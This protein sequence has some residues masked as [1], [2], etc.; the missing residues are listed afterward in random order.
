MTTLIDRLLLQP[1]LRVFLLLIFF[2]CII[3]FWPPLTGAAGTSVELPGAARVV[4]AKAGSLINEKNYKEAAKLIVTF[5]RQE[6]S[7]RGCFAAEVYHVLGICYLLDNKP[8]LAITALDKAIASD[9]K[10]LPARLNRAKAGYETGQYRDAAEHF[11]AAY[12]LAENKEPEHL[13]FAAV[14]YL[15]AK[16]HRKSIALFE[17]LLQTNPDN[18]R[19]EWRE[20]LVHAL[21]EVKEEKLALPHIVILAET[22]QGDKQTQWW[23]ILLN[24]Y[25]QLDMHGEAL[26]LARKLTREYPAE[27]KWWRGLAHIHLF[28]N[29][30]Q[31]A[32]SAMIILGYL[33]PL[34]AQEQRLVADLY[35]QLGVPGQAVATYQRL[36]RE[37]SSPQLLQNVVV[38]FQQ[39]GEL[40]AAVTAIDTFG[41][42]TLSP[43]LLM[44]KGDLLYR[45]GKFAAAAE[46]YSQ[47]AA[48]DSKDKKRAVQMVQYAR[49]QAVSAGL[50]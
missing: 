29:Q 26:A 14:A 31:P 18:F 39:L 20:N 4:L 21:L 48:L 45:L 50:N 43:E 46:M 49:G 33:V 7:D 37:K 44:Q 30:Y 42:D 12:E 10:H 8:N 22:C 24:E 13:Y 5:Q 32:L 9:P 3:L 35:L 15:L 19:L 41:G 23:E 36:L 11:Y 17:R 40:E 27:A 38:A 25:L 1:C 6:N 28:R 34:N 47:V 2:A 16:D